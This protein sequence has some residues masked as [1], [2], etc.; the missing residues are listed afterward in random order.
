EREQAMLAELSR[1]TTHEDR[2]RKRSWST[3]EPP[4]LPPE[5]TKRASYEYEKRKRYKIRD[6]CGSGV[7]E[8]YE[9]IFDEQSPNRLPHKAAGERIWMVSPSHPISIHKADKF[10][11]C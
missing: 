2:R 5:A 3:S 10:A 7:L 6:N 4:A 1:A 9:R 8:G 11:K